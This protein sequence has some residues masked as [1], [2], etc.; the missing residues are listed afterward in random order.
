MERTVSRIWTSWWWTPHSCTL[1]P[2]FWVASWLK[3]CQ[4]V[5]FWRDRERVDFSAPV[6]A[7]STTLSRGGAYT[8]ELTVKFTHWRFLFLKCKPVNAKKAKEKHV[9]LFDHVTA[10][11]LLKGKWRNVYFLVNLSFFIL[12][13]FNFDD[14]KR[15]QTVNNFSFI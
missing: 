3:N 7:T 9:L 6:A 14:F 15:D 2:S 11:A 4:T 12:E 13:S 5:L 8:A 1:S 10:R